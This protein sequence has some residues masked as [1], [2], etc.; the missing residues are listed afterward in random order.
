MLSHKY[1]QQATHTTELNPT[2]DLDNEAS[3]ESESVYTTLTNDL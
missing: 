3:R 1:L 2:S